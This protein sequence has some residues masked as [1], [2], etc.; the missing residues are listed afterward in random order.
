MRFFTLIT[1][2]M[3]VGCHREVPPAR[4]SA[5]SQTSTV[6]ATSSPLGRLA[7]NPFGRVA[8]TSVAVAPPAAAVGAALRRVPAA[9]SLCG[10]L[11]ENGL[12]IPNTRRPAVMAQLG[13]P[14]STRSQPTPNPHKPAQTDS[15]VDVFYPGLR[16]H[17]VVLGVEQGE[18]DILLRADV[19]DN[20]Y[21]KYPALGVGASVEAIVS[22][23]GQPEE[24]SNDTY[25]YS[26]ALHVMEGSTVYFHFQGDR[27]KFVEYTFY[28][29]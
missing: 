13:R 6:A 5:D 29:D 1:L 9:D 7:P 4:P 12:G 21:L 2:T 20:R 22:A 8:P 24:R 10:D 14:D 25:S 15:V 17:Y 23:L 16:L 27:V 18:T 26:C 19:S 11:A 28:A 3:L